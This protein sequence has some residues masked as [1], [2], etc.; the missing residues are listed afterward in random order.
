MSRHASTSIFKP[1]GRE[2][3]E[4]AR[5]L[6]EVLAGAIDPREWADFLDIPM[7]GSPELDVVRLAC[8]ALDSEESM[9]ANGI[10]TYTPKGREELQRLLR[11]LE[12]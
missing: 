1:F 5:I 8:A 2:D 7:K 6:G 4:V 9:D 10:I 12:R 3:A 11:S